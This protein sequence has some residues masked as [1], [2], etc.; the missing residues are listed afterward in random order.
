MKPSYNSHWEGTFIMKKILAIAAIAALAVSLPAAEIFR[1]DF[2]GTINASGYTAGPGDN[3]P[4]G[5][6]I[7]YNNPT[8]GA[9]PGQPTI[10]A[11]ATA[12]TGDGSV[13]VF[14]GNASQGLIV[15]PS[16]AISGDF[17]VEAIFR[18]DLADTAFAEYDLQQIVGNDQPNPDNQWAL[19]IDGSGI[20]G[21][22][23]GSLQG[24]TNGTAGEHN[25]GS[26]SALTFGATAWHH[27][28]ITYNSATNTVEMFLD[29]VSQGTNTPV[30]YSTGSW[31]HFSIGFW[32]NDASSNRH[33]VGAI[34]SI[35]IDNTVL[36][37]GGFTLPVELSVFSA[38]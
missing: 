21:L 8:S 22:T 10:T 5:W 9:D 34:D 38:D 30:S 36:A 35:A 12:P 17:T 13:C 25:V 28:V 24:M 27:A 31:Q 26:T 29:G 3:I 4:V 6:T 2:A 16:A 7:D 32:M 14:N 37:P 1:I 15:T 23:P 11:D 20:T 18:S 19:R 33:L